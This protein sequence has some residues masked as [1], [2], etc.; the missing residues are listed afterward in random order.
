MLQHNIID[1]WR[2]LES[3][4]ENVLNQ[5]SERSAERLKLPQ[6]FGSKFGPSFGEILRFA[7]DLND[8]NHFSVRENRRADDPLNGGSSQFLRLDAFEDAG[9]ADIGEI[10]DH[11]RTVIADIASGQSVGAGK[12]DLAYIAQSLRNQ[13]IQMAPLFRNREDCHLVRFTSKVLAMR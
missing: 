11:F 3:V 1:V 2:A 12:R 10:V 4:G 5:L 7:A 8:A 6:V 9:V 13:E